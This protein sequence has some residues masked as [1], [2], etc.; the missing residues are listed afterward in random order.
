LQF[1]DHINDLRLNA[2]SFDILS[3]DGDHAI[4]MG[5]GVVNGEVTVDFTLNVYDH[6]E[7]GSSDQFFIN[8]PE[9]DGYSAGGTLSGGNIMI[10]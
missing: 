7:P 2:S 5:T 3:I 8:I 9:L 10:H 6:G 4:I 1:V